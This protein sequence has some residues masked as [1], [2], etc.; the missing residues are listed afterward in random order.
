MIVNEKFLDYSLADNICFIDI[1]TTG[2]SKDDNIVMISYA[3]YFNEKKCKL[4]SLISEDVKKDEKNL[5]LEFFNFIIGV[6]ELYSFNGY[7]FEYPFLKEKI[8][9]HNINI[10]FDFKCTSLK[11]NIKN[12]AKYMGISSFSRENIE[13]YFGIVKSRYYDMRAMVNN[14]KKSNKISEDMIMHSDEEISTLL[15]MYEKFRN[16]KIKKVVIL[17]DNRY[18]LDDFII[19]VDSLQ[20]SFKSDMKS[21]YSKFFLEN[22]ESVI[23]LQYDVILDV[24]IKNVQKDDKSMILYETEKQYVPLFI[25]G[26]IIYD[27]IYFV[28]GELLRRC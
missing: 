6:Y 16:Q 23:L 13:N 15:F 8:K 27:N 10:N 4:V 24:F 11:S 14:I 18:Y 22:G 26:D 9:Y 12:F 2:L 19:N 25:C 21:K 17:Q 20:L 28:L 5:I 7:E 3:K 1:E